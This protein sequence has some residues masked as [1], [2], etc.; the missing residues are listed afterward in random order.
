MIIL[1]QNLGHR[2]FCVKVQFCFGVVDVCSAGCSSSHTHA[3]LPGH[4]SPMLAAI[5]RSTIRETMRVQATNPAPVLAYAWARYAIRYMEGTMGGM[6]ERADLTQAVLIP[7]LMGAGVTCSSGGRVRL[8]QLHA[9]LGVHQQ[10]ARPAASH[11]A[12]DSACDEQSARVRQAHVS[13]QR[14][15]CDRRLRVLCRLRPSQLRRHFCHGQYEWGVVSTGSVQH[16][17]ERWAASLV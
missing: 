14:L 13:R 2:P 3:G 8:R 11:V 1:D 7:A 17:H 12:L 4:N 10:R 5:T 15:V 6:L 16:G 9:I